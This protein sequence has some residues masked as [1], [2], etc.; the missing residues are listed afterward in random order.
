MA[1]VIYGNGKTQYGPGVR[2]NLTGCDVAVAIEAY[3][4]A[5]GIYTQGPRTIT[6]NGNM[7]ESG[8]IYVDPSGLVMHNGKRFSGRGQ[9]SEYLQELMHNGE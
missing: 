9:E 4:L 7:C 6:V 2:I 1:D 5:H 3:L 8:S